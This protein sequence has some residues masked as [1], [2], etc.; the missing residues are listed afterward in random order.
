MSAAITSSPWPSFAPWQRTSASII[1]RP[2]CNRAISYSRARRVAP[3]RSRL[4]WKRKRRSG[5]ALRSP[6]LSAA[7]GMDEARRCQSIPERSKGRSR[8]SRRHS[9]E[10]RP[11]AQGLRGA[12]SR[13]QGP[14]V[15]PRGG[16]NALRLLPRRPRR[17]EIHRATNRPHP[18]Y[19]LHR[20]QLEHRTETGDA[21]RRPLAHG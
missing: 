3:Q 7:R 15:F 18:G 17:V 14:R 1:P 19:D 11:R 9:A 6:P 8:P 4:Y 21:G 10:R 12:E 13:H 5:W 16:A 2:F 20:P